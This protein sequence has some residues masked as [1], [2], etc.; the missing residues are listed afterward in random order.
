MN[1]C[2]S[3][4]NT[5]GSVCSVSYEHLTLPIDKKVIV[6]GP[7]VR[8]FWG[9]ITP[10]EVLT[11]KPPISYNIERALKYLEG[12]PRISESSNVRIA[13]PDLVA[14]YIPPDRQ[15][16]RDNMVKMVDRCRILQI[17]TP[18]IRKDFRDANG[19]CWLIMDRVKGQSLEE[20]WIDLTF[21]ESMN[22]AWKLRRII[23]KLRKNR[24]GY[25]GSIHAGRCTSP[26]LQHELGLRKNADCHEVKKFMFRWHE[27]TPDQSLSCGSSLG[28]HDFRWLVLTHHN[29]S[30][31]NIMLNDTGEL[32]ILNSKSSGYYPPHF[33]GT[34]MY[35]WR[36]L[37]D[38]SRTTIPWSKEAERRWSIL[39]RVA[40]D[41]SSHEAAVIFH[42]QSQLHK[43]PKLSMVER[44]N[45]KE[46]CAP[47]KATEIS[48]LSRML[49][50]AS[51]ISM[52]RPR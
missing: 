30:P 22:I 52:R 26:F 50:N 14:K 49:S 37:M 9:A 5:Q 28:F 16:D 3:L 41:Y 10:P 21:L 29:L 1:S 7:K 47:R 27:Y 39:C 46:R 31:R 25:C 43:Y 8:E 6:S 20:I 34:A 33:E 36:D 51:R 15:D 19:G 13:S 2:I 17:N 11:T 42:I 44:W 38:P 12:C 40:G 23:K 24:R 18:R 45:S 32:V 35:H 4:P 48:G